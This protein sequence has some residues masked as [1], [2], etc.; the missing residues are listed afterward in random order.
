MM[1]KGSAIPAKEKITG[2]L[3]NVPLWE[4]RGANE[5]FWA[6][7]GRDNPISI[8]W[9]CLLDEKLGV[10]VMRLEAEKSDRRFSQFG[11]E[12]KDHLSDRGWQW[13]Q[14]R[15]ERFHLHFGYRT[16]MDR[17]KMDVGVEGKKMLMIFTWWAQATWWTETPLTEIEETKRKRLW[18]KVKSSPER[19]GLSGDVNMKA[20]D[21]SW[22]Y[23]TGA[24]NF[25]WSYQF[26]KYWHMGDI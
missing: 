25:S 12:I 3:E 11:C 7:E 6:N 4:H 5:G 24:Q 14:K 26:G 21:S 17:V 18:R 9:R 2:E 19:W 20:N 16:E 8:I 13:G 10:G 15:E 23:G 1:E 22:H